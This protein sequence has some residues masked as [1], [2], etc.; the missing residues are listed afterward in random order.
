M[1]RVEVEPRD[2]GGWGCWVALEIMV[3]V[4]NATQVSF[5]L[6]AIAGTGICRPRFRMRERHDLYPALTLELHAAPTEEHALK[7]RLCP[8][9]GWTH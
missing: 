8:A 5:L 4:E 6:F 3:I 9:C 7:E 2:L 1:A